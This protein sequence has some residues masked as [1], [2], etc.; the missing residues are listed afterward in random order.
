VRPFIRASREDIEAH[1]LRHELRVATDP[2]NRDPRY[3]R[4]RVRLELMPLMKQLSPTIR[5]HLC[6]LADRAGA[7]REGE[8]AHIYPLPRATQNALAEL[9][10]N[11]KA[12]TRILL[13]GGLVAMALGTHVSG[14][15]RAE[16]EPP[17]F[18]DTNLMRTKSVKQPR[19]G[20]K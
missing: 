18:R 2:S 4:T 10:R 11:Q 14:R 3:L 1:V 12:R 17:V 9:C 7:L 19:Q 13:P 8:G 15:P 6:A 20:R 16:V 5:E